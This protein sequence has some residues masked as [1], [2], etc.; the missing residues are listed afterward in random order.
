VRH[1]PSNQGQD[2]DDSDLELSS[3]FGGII[4]EAAEPSARS[5]TR[6]NAPGA[7]E[8]SARSHNK[9]GWQPQAE[10]PA[11]GSSIPGNI[12]IQSFNGN[13][14]T[15]GSGRDAPDGQLAATGTSAQTEA[16]QSWHMPPSAYSVKAPSSVP[17]LM[18]TQMHTGGSASAPQL[19]QSTAGQPNNAHSGNVRAS[20]SSGGIP[21]GI[22]STGNWTAA[23]SVPTA[24]LHVPAVSPFLPPRQ[25]SPSPFLANSA[26]EGRT[27]AGAGGGESMAALQNALY[28]AEARA[29]AAESTLQQ[30]SLERATGAQGSPPQGQGQ[31]AAQL[32]HARLRIAQL[33]SENTQLVSQV[34]SAQDEA[35]VAVARLEQAEALA[36]GG[37][38]GGG[39]GM[40]GDM[41]AATNEARATA[42]ATAQQCSIAMLASVARAWRRRQLS[43]CWGRWMAAAASTGAQ[44]L[45]RDASEREAALVQELAHLQ[46]QV[47]A[48]SKTSDWGSEVL[49]LRRELSATREALARKDQQLARQR[50]LFAH[51]AVARVGAH[52]EEGAAAHDTHVED[53]E[54]ELAV[55][56]AVGGWRFQR[57]A[58][59]A[60]VAERETQIHTLLQ[61]VAAA[62]VDQPHRKRTS[63][64]S[65]Q[66]RAS[67]QVLVEEA[68]GS[69][70]AAAAAKRKAG[71][72]RGLLSRMRREGRAHMQKSNA[73]IVRLRRWL[74]RARRQLQRDHDDDV[75]LSTAPSQE[76]LGHASDACSLDSS[77]DR[78]DSGSGGG[79]STA[80]SRDRAAVSLPETCFG[81]V[82]AS[83]VDSLGRPGSRNSGSSG[84]SSGGS[85]SGNDSSGNS[86]CSAAASAPS[87][88]GSQGGGHGI[89]D[90]EGT[91]D[92]GMRRRLGGL[93]CSRSPP[94][95]VAAAVGSMPALL[96]R[97]LQ[98]QLKHG[99]SVPTAP[100]LGVHGHMGHGAPSFG[101][102]VAWDTGGMGGLR[103]HL[104][105]PTGAT[106]GHAAG[107]TGAPLFPLLQPASQQPLPPHLRGQ[108]PAGLQGPLRPSSAWG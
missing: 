32:T 39:G 21:E 10:Q 75:S 69:Q 5:S 67:A 22:H 108:L 64:R 73:R 59:Q 98:S 51:K 82:T 77:S 53:S 102:A 30:L 101:A 79:G 7:A 55:Q 43:R 78:S 81:S 56:A 15:G 72:L 90:Q 17:Q 85:D 27:P 88:T 48:L 2:S 40:V 41:L 37:G 49:R 33:E 3:S 47:D 93:E 96:D 76:G 45:Q 95:P 80:S 52:Q 66:R 34:S 74:R 28:D 9:E 68:V 6:G 25:A 103:G 65:Q 16:P 14:I 42:D 60:M 8:P 46:A 71:A 104:Q 106:G 57:A 61:A 11:A 105:Y 107:A 92:T 13:L 62:S 23:Q 19:A 58:L 99:A 38:G 12:T 36:T 29:V 89:W 54:L 44:R 18:D 94:A 97:L 50:A 1:A 100:P 87:S 63:K 31:A 4:R 24:S 86:R 70:Q 35:A 20:H 26:Q 91:D 84:S 83:Q